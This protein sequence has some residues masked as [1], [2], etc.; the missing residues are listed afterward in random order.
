MRHQHPDTRFARDFADAYKDFREET[1]DP[2]RGITAGSWNGVNIIITQTVVDA[3]QV[4]SD[5]YHTMF[6]QLTQLGLD[7]EMITIIMREAMHAFVANRLPSELS[8]GVEQSA[9][10]ATPTLERM[11]PGRTPMVSYQQVLVFEDYFVHISVDTPDPDFS[12]PGPSTETVCVAIAHGGTREY[13]LEKL[14]RGILVELIMAGAI[15]LPKKPTNVK[16]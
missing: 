2:H 4:R 13:M 7:T 10:L 14:P 16:E 15:S 12:R 11:K 5:A 3:F 6:Q 9:P 8:E 1:K